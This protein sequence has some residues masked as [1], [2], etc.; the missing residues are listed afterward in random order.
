MIVGLV[1]ANPNNSV[2]ALKLFK[3][4]FFENNLNFYFT[5]GAGIVSGGGTV[6]GEFLGGGGAEFF[7]PGLES[8]GWTLEMGASATTL[9]G[10]LVL[11]TY[12]F[13][14]VDAGM[15]FYF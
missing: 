3:N 9:T 5:V 2:T 6:G 8:I 15:R 10:A 4:V 1:S 14:F 7:I 13:S 11:R 12:G